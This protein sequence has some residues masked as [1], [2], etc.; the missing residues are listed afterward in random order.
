MNFKQFITAPRS[1][2]HVDI[3]WK[4]LEVMIK[5]EKVE[6]GLDMDP[7]FQRAHVWTEQQQI[8]YIE[9]ILRGGKSGKDLYFNSYDYP[10]STG[11]YV[12]VDGK[13]RVQA[14]KQFMNGKIKV[15]GHYYTKG[16]RLDTF[17]C[18]FSWNIAS[19]KTRKE[20]LRWYLDFNSGGTDH[21]PEELDKVGK[22]LDEMSREKS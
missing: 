20:V 11:Y 15:F 10:E 9:Y 17:I 16:D 14:V 4:R 7:D 12:I 3:E 22:M 21:T 2:Y 1:L 6:M 13:Q 8:A 5:N 18:S 19:L